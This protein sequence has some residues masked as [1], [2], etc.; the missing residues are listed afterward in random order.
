MLKADEHCGSCWRKE[1]KWIL[2]MQAAGIQAKQI[3]ST[4]Q[5][6]LGPRTGLEPV[7]N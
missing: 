3:A 7:G 2:S 1:K 5:F 6:P 4:L